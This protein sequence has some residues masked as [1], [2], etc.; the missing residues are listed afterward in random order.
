[1][2]LQFSDKANN[3]RTTIVT[4]PTSGIDSYV[5]VYTISHS[6]T[7]FCL[8]PIDLMNTITFDNP[9][10]LYITWRANVRAQEG[11]YLLLPTYITVILDGH[12]RDQ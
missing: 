1:M 3:K 2:H 7:Q 6:S 9:D 8:I 11:K 5:C 10:R 4:F 12:R